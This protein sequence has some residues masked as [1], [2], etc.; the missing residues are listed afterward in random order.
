M[1]V[2]IFV[3]T[4]KNY[5]MPE[6]KMYFPIQAGSN[7]KNSIGYLRDDS[8]D[9]ISERNPFYCELTATYWVWKNIDADY[10]GIAHYRRHFGK[11][12]FPFLTKNQKWKN[13]LDRETLIKLT[14]NADIILPKKRVYGIE[15]NEQ[16]YSHSSIFRANELTLMR[17]ILQECSNKIYFQAFETVLCRRW[18]HM[19]NMYIMS[20]KKFSKFN[21]WQ[22]P[23]L[24]EFEKR[25][26]RSQYPPK[27]NRAWIEELMVDTWVEANHYEYVECPVMFMEKQNWLKKGGAF[28][29]RKIKG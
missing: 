20:K 21:E 1:D 24:F 18:A 7:G 5:Q 23:L 14:E 25:L 16:H 19:F 8:G 12:G 3:A 26:D 10:I 2:R 9:N 22:F 29:Y 6:D 15:T 11:S 4:H 17:S 28:I 27:E 13:V